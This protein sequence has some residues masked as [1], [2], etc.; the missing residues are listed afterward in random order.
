MEYADGIIYISRYVLTN[1]G[2][3]GRERERRQLDACL[4][5]AHHENAKSRVSCF[6]TRI[7]LNRN[8]AREQ[9]ENAKF[10]PFSLCL[11]PPPSSPPLSLSLSLSL[12]TSDFNK[13]NSI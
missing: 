10:I 6:Y 2:E 9:N 12:A 1:S 5:I 4:Y 8:C 3:G 13:W 7:P 11:L